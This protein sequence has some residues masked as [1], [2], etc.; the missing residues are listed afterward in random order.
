[1]A[2][3]HCNDQFWY[4][5]DPTTEFLTRHVHNDEGTQCHPL[6]QKRGVCLRSPPIFLGGALECNNDMCI[7]EDLKW[8]VDLVTLRACRLNAFDL[9][10]L[11]ALCG[12]PRARHFLALIRGGDTPVIHI[13]PEGWSWLPTVTSNVTRAAN[14]DVGFCRVAL[15]MAHT[16]QIVIWERSTNAILR[17]ATCPGLRD[18]VA[19]CHTGRIYGLTFEPNQSIVTFDVAS[20]TVVENTPVG[21]GMVTYGKLNAVPCFPTEKITP[22]PANEDNAWT[23]HVGSLVMGVTNKKILPVQVQA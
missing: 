5:W 16:S 23:W 9:S 6:S 17:F 15:F 1:M 7:T 21:D 14:C 13:R 19:C 11:K 20:M 8:C 18:F 2:R 3:Y 12:C 4:R 22:V 10:N